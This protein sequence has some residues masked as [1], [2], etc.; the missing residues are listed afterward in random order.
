MKKNIIIPALSVFLV[1]LFFRV[2]E[3]AAFS[4]SVSED[5]GIIT[6]SRGQ[7]FYAHAEKQ[8][9][10][11]PV[12]VLMKVRTG[13][14]I[15]IDKDS[16]VV[17]LYQANGRREAWKCPAMVKIGELDGRAE[18]DNNGVNKPSISSIPI[19]VNDS[20]VLSSLSDIQSAKKSRA[21]IR[22]VRGENDSLKSDQAEGM[23]IYQKLQKDLGNNDATPDLYLYS[24]Y[25]SKGLEKEAVVQLDSIQKKWGIASWLMETN[26]KQLPH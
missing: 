1:L 16:E 12:S 26:Q 18:D 7:V 15:K 21:G 2:S 14:I 17:I 8:G 11:K 10:F 3:T 4:S 9:E 23:S 22:V 25:R 20:I 19:E 6:F 13:D 24:Y 5:A